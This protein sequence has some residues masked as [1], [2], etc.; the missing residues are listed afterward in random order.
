MPQIKKENGCGEICTGFLKHCKKTLLMLLL[1]VVLFPSEIGGA[2]LSF[3][4]TVAMR[5]MVP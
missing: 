5:R 4:R 2:V 1:G 3:I